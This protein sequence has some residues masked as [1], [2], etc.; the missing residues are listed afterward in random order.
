MPNH[1]PHIEN[2]VS[3]HRG[4]RNFRNFSKKRLNAFKQG[5]I[6]VRLEIRKQAIMRRNL[7]KNILRKLTSLFFKHIRTQSATYREYGVFSTEESQRLLENELLPIM[8]R[9][10]RKIYI[11]IFK[12]NESKYEKINKS[13]DVAVFDRN[14]D[15]ES[16]VTLYNNERDLFLVNVTATISRTI[17]KVIK[18]GREEALSLAQIARK[19]NDTTGI[20]RR[21][22]NAIA[23]TETHNAVSFAQHEYH[24]TVKDEYGVKMMKRWAATNDLRTRSAHSAVNGQIRD[25]DEPFDV[26]GAQMMHAGDPKGGAKNVINCRCLIIYVDEDELDGISE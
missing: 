19:I 6:N 10:Y 18:E 3:A 5:R 12:D 16:L 17:E 21:R 22:A 2:A 14:R 4:A 1:Y 11:T 15:I 8:K 7:E 20:A 23:R 24:K 13:V 26:G 9:H 25:M